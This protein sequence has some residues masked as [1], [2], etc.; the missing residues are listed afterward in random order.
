M[1]NFA[2]NA[3]RKNTVERVKVF[4]QKR[5]KWQPEILKVIDADQIRPRFGGT[6]EDTT[7][8]EIQDLNINLKEL[9]IKD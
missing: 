3:L 1:Y 8:A 4:G 5:H 7:T 2:K 6:K 9:K